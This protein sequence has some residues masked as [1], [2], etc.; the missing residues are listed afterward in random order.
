MALTAAVVAVGAASAYSQSQKNK[1]GKAA[2][3]SQLAG[4]AAA[5]DNVNEAYD[6]AGNKLGQVTAAGMSQRAGVEQGIKT[7]QG[8]LGVGTQTL[9]GQQGALDVNQFLD[10][11][12]AFQEKEGQRALSASA[13]SRGGLL[14]GGAMKE[15]LA[16]SQGLASTNY[17]NAV[18]QALNNRGQQIN[19]GQAQTGVGIQGL[20]AGSN[21]YSQFGLGG[22]QNEAGML[23]QQG[24]DNATLSQSTGNINAARDA[25]SRNA[26][27]TGLASAANAYGGNYLSGWSQGKT[28]SDE[29]LKHEVSKITDA[30]ID[31]FLKLTPYEYEYTEDAKENTPGATDGKKFGVMAQDLEKSKIG[32]A[33][34]DKDE[35]GYRNVD[36]PMSV[37][38]LLATAASMNHRLK[39]LEGK[40]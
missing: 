21:I 12:M 31:E 11:S 39:K 2:A 4:V 7:A 8:Q 14:S 28:P 10:P 30:D 13:A 34:V 17:N 23:I 19:I 16:Y 3:N 29:D 15:A 22:L 1:A 36:I 6:K 35:R 26:I 20:Q 5:R 24:Q 37:S 9:A 32:K 38:A 33:L 25:N 27:G 40:K 18:Q